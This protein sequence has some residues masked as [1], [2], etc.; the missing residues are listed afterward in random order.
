MKILTNLESA[1]YT[2]GQVIVPYQGVVHDLIF[3]SKGKCR[4]YGFYH[5]REDRLCKQIL[6][7]LHEQSWYGDFPILLDI[8]SSFQLE[9]GKPPAQSKNASSGDTNSKYVQVLK[10][11]AE[12]FKKILSSYPETRRNLLLR[13]T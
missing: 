13:A 12:T 8:S 7:R 3:V 9:A 5:D 2:E 4:L 11:N 6:V 1:H 10:L